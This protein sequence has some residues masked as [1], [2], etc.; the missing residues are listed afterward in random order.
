MPALELK[1]IELSRILLVNVN[2]TV[3]ICLY[4]NAHSNESDR[5]VS[6]IL[7]MLS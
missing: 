5:T 4:Q 2:N 1:F 7:I 6:V 3:D